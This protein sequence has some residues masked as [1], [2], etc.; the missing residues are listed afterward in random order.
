MDAFAPELGAQAS[1][2]LTVTD[3]D[4]ALAVYSGGIEVLASPR[5]FALLET[6]AT[7]AIAP[8]L[9]A[10][11]QTVGI[12]L[13]VRHTAATPVGGRVTATARLIEIDR[14]RLVFAVTAVDEAGEV[15][16]GIHERFLV[17]AAPFLARAQTRLGT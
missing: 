17:E 6:A 2:Q 1:L 8:F 3:R 14:R 9:P 5:L 15:G 4:T 13:D 7:T 16:S 12:H 11:W 10:G